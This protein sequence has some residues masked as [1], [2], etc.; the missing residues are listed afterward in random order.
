MPHISFGKNSGS[1]IIT[2]QIPIVRV[3]QI[4]GFTY[5]MYLADTGIYEVQ[6]IT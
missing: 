2:E 6:H 1:S 5:S 4:Q 3:K